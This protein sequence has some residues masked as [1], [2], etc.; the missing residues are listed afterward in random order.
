MSLTFSNAR[1][2]IFDL[3][4]FSAA[5]GPAVDVSWRGRMSSFCPG[6]FALKIIPGTRVEDDNIN[7]SI[8]FVSLIWVWTSEVVRSSSCP[9]AP[10][11]MTEE[12]LCD[13][14]DVLDG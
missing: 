7:E 14:G 11:T 8:G 5:S 13:G 10:D 6:K 12:L 4:L 3:S 1:F 9:S 2:K